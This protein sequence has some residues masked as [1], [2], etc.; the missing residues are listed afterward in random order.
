M[1]AEGAQA[2]SG[3]PYAAGDAAQRAALVVGAV[4]SMK[5]PL[6]AVDAETASAVVPAAAVVAFSKIKDLGKGAKAE[7]NVASM[8][9]Q[10]VADACVVA[11]ASS[12]LTAAGGAV[13]THSGKIPD[14]LSSMG[15]AFSAPEDH[16]AATVPGVSSGT[17]K[18]R[19]PLSGAGNAA[20]TPAWRFLCTSMEVEGQVTSVA[21]ILARHNHPA[22]S[23]TLARFSQEARAVLV[24]VGERLAAWFG[25]GFPDVVDQRLKT[26]L[27]PTGNGGYV[28]VSPLYPHGLGAEIAARLAERD[29]A[30]GQRF[31][32]R[33]VKVGG[34]K[35]Q[36]AGMLASDLAGN[37]WRFL[38]LPPEVRKATGES[39]AAMLAR[40][41]LSLSGTRVRR[42]S[43]DELVLALSKDRGNLGSRNRIK[44]ALRGVVDDILSPVS[45]IHEA[46]AVARAEGRA[47]LPDGQTAP[48]TV[49]ARL[50]GLS[51]PFP[52]LVEVDEL[53]GEVADLALGRIAGS[54]VSAPD[55]AWRLAPDDATRSVV[56]DIAEEAILEFKP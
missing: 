47:V 34:T 51:A 12:L 20:D 32:R 43:V 16:P 39:L 7:A 8:F 13:G 1:D 27:M 26:V 5:A 53:A 42:E 33:V 46:V 29:A 28:A 41:G 30:L 14:P 18:A 48:S 17:F 19:K 40:G 6:L 56:R 45:D 10:A 9:D 25:T 3:A 49:L 44:D 35:P 38:A 50:S 37:F 55:G 23:A 11:A 36:N 2:A 24:A 54:V 31:K 21:D 4:F 22:R 15:A 52:N